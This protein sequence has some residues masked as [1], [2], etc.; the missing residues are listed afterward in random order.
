MG[1]LAHGETKPPSLWAST[2]GAGNQRTGY[3]LEKAREA[4]YFVPLTRQTGYRVGC[5]A[6]V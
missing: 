1:W 2:D 6:A 3:R 4:E 5:L